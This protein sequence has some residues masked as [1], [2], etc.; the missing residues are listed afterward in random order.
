M[1][2]FG[3]YDTSSE[4]SVKSSTAVKECRD[5]GLS[6]NGGILVNVDS[7]FEPRSIGLQKLF[8]YLYP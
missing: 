8:Y 4:T 7:E 1:F 6:L 2:S 5:Y 3:P